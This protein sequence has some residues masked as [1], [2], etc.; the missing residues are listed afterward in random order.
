MGHL[1][2]CSLAWLVALSRLCD[3][4]HAWSP[5]EA[6]SFSVH[7][8]SGSDGAVVARSRREFAAGILAGFA[9][10]SLAA[11]P[12]PARAF[13]NKISN[14][15]DDRPKRRG[16]KPADLGVR[17]R[18]S[19][20]GD[21]DDYLG[22][23]GCGPAPNCFSSTLVDDDDHDIPA[24]VWPAAYGDDQAR[25]FADLADVLRAYPP[26]QSGVDGGGFQ[27][28]AVDAEA[29]YAYV[30]YEALRNGYI[31]DVE[32][33]VVPGGPPRSLQVRSSSRVGYL[34]YGVNAKRLNWIASGLRS[35]GWDAVGVDYDKHR[36]Y[37]EENQIR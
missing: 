10:A 30:Q 29:G 3:P 31:D 17:V 26:G 4:I 23:K 13:D 1:R 33:A 28:Q 22:L 34:D 27:I 36:F 35:K 19:L 8:G 2:L 12:S 5:S 11:L 9:A 25:A 32:F 6:R 21:E 7:G 24:W 15:Y 16:P 20:G 37:A 14:Q 18:Q